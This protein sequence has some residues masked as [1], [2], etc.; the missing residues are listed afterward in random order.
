M[1]KGFIC[2]ENH[3]ILA[4]NITLIIQILIAHINTCVRKCALPSA[5]IIQL[6]SLIVEV[7]DRLLIRDGSI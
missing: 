5:Y 2:F 6:P 7:V 3:I 4:T 1:T